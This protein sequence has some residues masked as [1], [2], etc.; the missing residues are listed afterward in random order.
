MHSDSGCGP[1]HLLHRTDG[2][3]L[4]EGDV[5]GDGRVPPAGV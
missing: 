5:A 3:V 4:L 1:Q 2:G